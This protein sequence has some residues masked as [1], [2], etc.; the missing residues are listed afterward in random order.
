MK[1]ILIS[2]KEKHFNATLDGS[3]GHEFRRKIPKYYKNLLAFIY[4]TKP[5]G[6]IKGYI[7]FGPPIEGN[8]NEMVSLQKE[9]NYSSEQSIREYFAGSPKC[10]ALPVKK[11][12][13]F[14]PISLEQIRQKISN[15]M[16]PQ[17]YIYL[18]SKELI[19]LIIPN[20]PEYIKEILRPKG[21]F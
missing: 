7:E 6:E 4:V 17:S 16:P 3:K 14:T 13:A 5:V 8:I 21:L 11:S 9:H 18:R 15:F 10:F 2:L 20:V 1:T 12:T 19:D